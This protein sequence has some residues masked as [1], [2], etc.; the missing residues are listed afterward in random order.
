MTLAKRICELAH[1]H[2]SLRAA[3]RVVRIDHGYLWRLYKGAKK[4]PSAAVLRKLGLKRIVSYERSHDINSEA[5][6]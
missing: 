3:A 2:G 5:A 1:Q 6:K 4:E